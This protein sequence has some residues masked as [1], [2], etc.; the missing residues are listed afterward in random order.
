MKKLPFLR[1]HTILLSL[2]MFRDNQSRIF[3]QRHFILIEDII[4]IT[5]RELAAHSRRKAQE[6]E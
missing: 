3:F 4:I 2:L 5:S 1:K 6:I